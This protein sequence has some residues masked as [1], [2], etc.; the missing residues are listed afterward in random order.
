MSRALKEKP[1]GSRN[2]TIAVATPLMLLF[3]ACS[4]SQPAPEPVA[5]R[6][7]EATPPAP[8]PA[9]QQVVI[10]VRKEEPA[11]EAPP[12]RAGLTSVYFAFDDS[13]LD[14]DA[15]ALLD[16]V[17]NEMQRDAESHARVEGNCDERGT[18]E[19]NLAL[20]QRRA[21][22]ARKY[23]ADLGVANDRVG[24]MSWGKERPKAP[25]HDV[26]AWRTNRRDDVFIVMPALVGAR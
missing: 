18:S 6:P 25:G 2:R 3:G 26:D 4:H 21:D 10:E 14:A 16:A 22:A 9:P 7:V 15:R 17:A 13:A 23:L 24:A 8:P 5:Q 20:G 1:M 12:P 19:Y 11:A